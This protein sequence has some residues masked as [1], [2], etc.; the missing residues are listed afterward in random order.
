MK[1]GMRLLIGILLILCVIGASFLYWNRVERDERVGRAVSPTAA[2]AFSHDQ[3]DQV[4]R[5]Y[6]DSQGRVN[7]AALKKDS[8][9]L[10]SYL[11]QLAVTSPDNLP[12]RQD[13]L[14]FWIN[15]YNALTIKGVIDHYPTPSVRRIKPLGGFFRRIIYQVGG[16]SYTLNDIEHG[17]I[18][19]KFYEPRIHFALVCASKGCPQLENRAFLP[20][21]LEEQLENATRNFINNPEKVRL[22]HPDRVLYLSKIF[23]WYAED[24]EE[25]AD[26]VIDFIAVYMSQADAA[27][28]KQEGI[29]VKYL[30]Y[31][32]TLN[33]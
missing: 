27:F 16:H 3:F 13:K 10:E 22:E 33:N 25:R 12:T 28:I 18:R 8:Q 17:I 2:D 14:A 4:L 31:D 11:D 1:S 15:A 23:E 29:Q 21:T 6:V 26:N 32:W 24:F 20:D 7:Y 9:A 19:A 5:Q 30:D